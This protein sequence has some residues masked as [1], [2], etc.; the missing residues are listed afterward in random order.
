MSSPESTNC[1]SPN[2]YLGELDQEL[3]RSAADL[4]HNSEVK[5]MNPFP[6]S[7]RTIAELRGRAGSVLPAATFFGGGSSTY[8]PEPWQQTVVQSPGPFGG[9]ATITQDGYKREAILTYNEVIGEDP[10]SSESPISLAGKY[11]INWDFQQLATHGLRHN[12]DA[13]KYEIVGKTLTEV[14]QNPFYTSFNDSQEGATYSTPVGQQ[15]LLNMDRGIT[16]D[17][18]PY[19]QNAHTLVLGATGE[20]SEKVEV[21]PLYEGLGNVGLLHYHRA[22]MAFA[23]QL[24]QAPGDTTFVFVFV[25]SPNQSTAYL[26]FNDSKEQISRG[27]WAVSEQDD[28]TS[29]LM[30]ENPSRTY[31]NFATRDRT[32]Y[33]RAL[34]NNGANSIYAIH[35]NLPALLDSLGINQ[36]TPIHHTLVAHSAGSSA[37]LGALNALQ[38]L[39]IEDVNMLGSALFAGFPQGTETAMNL[40]RDRTGQGHAFSPLP[41]H[42]ALPFATSNL[43]NAIAKQLGLFEQQPQAA[44]ALHAEEDALRKA[45]PLTLNVNLH[46]IT[47][48]QDAVADPEKTAALARAIDTDPTNRELPGAE[49]GN[50]PMIYTFLNELMALVGVMNGKGEC[51]K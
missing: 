47:T 31:L 46:S 19:S 13:K 17:G 14:T 30:D 37:A 9:T 15:F 39:A 22:I 8:Y 49:H 42:E 34:V 41:P 1:E 2:P 24:K 38:S 7:P 29:P 28:V 32:G 45:E 3:S 11:G 48:P 43:P 20:A 27:S 4:L 50:I 44:A 33:T 26:G 40:T 36:S 35:D 6:I 51:G 25:P 16:E 21:I 23:E 5:S 10:A 18:L 12:P